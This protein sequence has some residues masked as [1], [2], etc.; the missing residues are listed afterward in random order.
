MLSPI[1]KK[2]T[3]LTT[4]EIEQLYRLHTYYALDPSPEAAQ[5]YIKERHIDTINPT[6]YLYQEAGE[7]IAYQGLNLFYRQTPFAKKPLPILYISLAFKAV[8]ADNTIKNY[9]QQSN[10]HF[11][12]QELGYFW[13]LHPFILSFT[14]FNPK[15]IE[16][17]RRVM[18]DYYPNGTT[19]P[20][21]TVY[22]FAKKYAQEVLKREGSSLTTELVL[23]GGKDRFID[24]TDQWT[25]HYQSASPSLNQFFMA[26][27]IIVQ[28]GD[29]YLLRENS[30]VVYLG[31]YHPWH[32]LQRKLG[33]KKRASV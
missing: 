12:K 13:Q 25:T 3:A 9:V 8:D 33:F 10:V 4:E 20:P 19:S 17:L 23:Q 30:M 6:F 28:Q 16:R 29:R 24:L 5:Y 32:L 7:I 1:I 31:Y 22:E 11:L 27:N 21:K 18:G 2:G 26:Q 14:T 15:G